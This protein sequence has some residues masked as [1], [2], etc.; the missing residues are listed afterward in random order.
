MSI[1][2]QA[3]AHIGLLR[4]LFIDPTVYNAI[5]SSVLPSLSLH[6]GRAY[7]FV[8]ISRPVL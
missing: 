1:A 5:R 8:F 4:G 3:D 7:Q 6:K 2:V